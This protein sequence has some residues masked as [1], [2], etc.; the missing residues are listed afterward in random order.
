MRSS[1]EILDDFL[2]GTIEEQEEYLTYLSVEYDYHVADGYTILANGC[3]VGRVLYIRNVPQ[4]ATHM[5]P[6]QAGFKN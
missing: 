6:K 5:T 1:I 4:V 3:I 2:D